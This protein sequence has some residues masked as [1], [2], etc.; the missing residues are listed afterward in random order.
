MIAG[1]RAGP[2]MNDELL[3]NGIPSTLTIYQIYDLILIA[4][5]K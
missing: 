1:A 5:K 3:S 4:I 2:R